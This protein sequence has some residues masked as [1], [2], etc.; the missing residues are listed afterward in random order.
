MLSGN[1]SDGDDEG[2][3]ESSSS[4]SSDTT[5]ANRMDNMA[6]EFR[7]VLDEFRENWQK[8]L[9]TDDKPTTNNQNASLNKS[10]S[11]DNSTSPEVQAEDLFKHAVE[12][13]QRGKVYDA[14]QYYRRAVQLDPDI[15]FK[16]YEASKIPQP[17]ENEP[18]NNN[19]VT[20]AKGK[21][22]VPPD[23]EDDE[24][25]LEKDLFIRFQNDIAKQGRLIMSNRDPGVIG[26]EMHISDLPTEILL[27]ILRW[28]VS[29]QLDMKSLE[30]CAAVC[31]G[32]Y[33]CA[34]DE[35]IWRQ[36][37]LKVWGVNLGCITGTPYDSWRQMFIERE[38]I[39]FN[40]CYISK[41]TYL[42][43][44]ENS[45]QDQFYR[46]VQLVEYYRYIRFMPDGTVL[47]MTSSDE[48]AQGVTRLKNLNQLRSEVLRGHYRLHGDTVTVMLKKNQ[49]LPKGDHYYG[50]GKRR[51]SVAPGAND[52]EANFT[53][54][55][56]EFNIASTPKKRF[57][58]LQWK[59]YSIIL[60]RNKR[61]VSSDFE[62]TP[63]KYPPLRFSCV[64]SYHLDAEAPL[65]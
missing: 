37:C 5:T 54:Y 58:Q 49:R 15:E 47:M 62:L 4:S 53:T 50:G 36:A 57:S 7:S 51:G 26:T 65:Q 38:R 31:K 30:Q 45:F 20:A 18:N 3:A 19:N 56:I 10:L 13:E 63:S 34:R 32:I 6:N 25:P 52:I 55:Y 39:H 14:L 61:E 11:L 9:K 1:K 64:R 33:L 41:T 17:I 27:Y 21:V 29:T 2:E 24:E 43:L 59:N 35:E 12:L 48:P 16:A 23:E 40:G 44:G 60:V 22:D 46:P 28:V 42:R 8:E